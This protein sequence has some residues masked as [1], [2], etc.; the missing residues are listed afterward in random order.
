MH[1]AASIQAPPSRWFT[2]DVQRIFVAQVLFGFGWSL[3]LLIPKFLATELRA[4]PDV[5]GHIGGIGGLAGL[6]T[7][8]FAAYGLDRFARRYFFGWAAL[9]ILLLSLGFTLVHEVTWL[10]Y[11][12]QGCVSAAFVLAFNATAALLADYAPPAQMGKA[13]GWLGGANVGMNAVATVIAE[14]LAASHGW[15][16]V[17]WLGIAAGAAALTMSFW[18]P[19]SPPRAAAVAADGGEGS[20]H[21]MLRIAPLLASTLLMGAAFNAMFGFVQPYAVS[22]GAREVRG[23][24]VGYTLAVVAGRM[25]LGGLGDRFGRR[26]VS[27]IMLVGYGLAAW[28]MR[29][30]DVELL[31]MYGVAFGTAHG[32]AYPTINALLLDLLPATRRGLGMVLFNGAFGLGGSVGSFG[33]GVLAQHYGYPMIYVVAALCALIASGMLGAV[34]PAR[35]LR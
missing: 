2:R 9:L 22:L 23:F 27:M 34:R 30:L 1:D 3:Y 24:F 29:Q 25:L 11:V 8:P 33:W 18:L 35:A 7:I 5:I 17:F 13:I 19:S 16:A 28:L 10:V 20:A 32:I 14:P 21:V 4:E 31:S 15:R 26:R 12:L 6:L